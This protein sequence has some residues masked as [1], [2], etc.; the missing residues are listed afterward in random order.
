MAY[1]CNTTIL[2]RVSCRLALAVLFVCLN[3][4]FVRAQEH[5]HTSDDATARIWFPYNNYVFSSSYMGNSQSLSKLDNAI[6]KAD[7][8]TV[9]VSVVSYSSPEGNANYNLWLSNQR[10]LA[11]QKYLVKTYP[12][13][14]DRITIN[15]GA[16]S[17]GE[18]R[19]NISSDTRLDEDTRARILNIIDSNKELD[20]KE[21]E[22]KSLSNY[23]RL[24]S[25]H[26][27]G[28]RY[29]DIALVVGTSAEATG[30]TTNDAS[31]QQA[32]AATPAEADEATSSTAGRK[33]VY[34]AVGESEV[35]PAYMDNEDS[36]YEI[37]HILSGPVNV[38]NI[39]VVGAASPEGS[40]KLNE[41][42]SLRRAESF[43]K[44]ILEVCPQ[45]EGKIE[46]VSLGENWDGLRDAVL[47]SE[48][49]SAEQ[50][51]EVVKIIDSDNSAS[52]KEVQLK[53]SSAWRIINRNI[54]PGLRFSGIDRIEFEEVADTTV[55]EPVD[56]TVV[57]PVDSTVVE[58]VDSTVKQPVDSTI[59]APVDSTVTSTSDS[60]VVAPVDSTVVAPVDSTV[61]APVDS[62]FTQ[63]ADTTM[64]ADTTKAR[65]PKTYY[66]PQ[67]MILALKTNLLY[68][69]VSALNFELEVPIGRRFSLMV[70]D[71]FPWWETGNKY[72]FEMWEIG[73]EPRFWF[74]PWDVN[75]SEKLRGFF[76]G[77]YA[78]SSKYDFQYD[79]SFNYQGEY[80]SA[81]I[82]GGYA[83]PIGR[84]FKRLDVNLELSMSIG[85]MH[86]DYRH[87]LPAD[88]YSMLIRDPYNVGTV[89]YFGP[90]KAKAS[91]VLTLPARI[92]EVRYE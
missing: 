23:R 86:S 6:S 60:T 80:W 59:V 64:K 27:R 21:T 31:A 67:R 57:E 81:G 65:E 10:A 36:I 17:W 19:A 24:Y 16:E 32:T 46:V 47:A 92:K 73:V 50:K 69:V 39:V 41:E 70:E 8:N 14:G 62:T 45:A 85:F 58:P 4:F 52:R 22:L 1:F 15:A 54:L 9:T 43:V 12:F 2:N 33:V 87:Y 29:A 71:V 49:L 61:V 38:R 48:D 26:F 78:M 91:L 84:L 13:L 55:V 42:L 75:S 77:P 3:S 68:D 74:T 72:C 40:E 66:R 76:V 5:A 34:Y 53:A 90:T 63:P 11:V 35:R 28:L 20:V 88:D 44:L 30:T 82:S 18:L 79:T 56:S 37:R 25:N 89:S 83:M 51:E 7:P